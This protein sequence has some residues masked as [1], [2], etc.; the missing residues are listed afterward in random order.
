MGR[1]LLA[2]RGDDGHRREYIALFRGLAAAGGHDVEARDLKPSDVLF[3]GAIFSPMLEEH[4]GRFFAIA[5]LRSMWGRKSSAL[6]FRPAEAVHSNALKHRVKRAGLAALRRL[7]G[8]EILTIL[9]FDLD[10]EFA[11]VAKDWIHDPQLWDLAPDSDETPVALIDEVRAKAAG[12]RV[13]VALGAQNAGKGF[14]YFAELWSARPELRERF[15][16]VAAGKVAA[17]SRASADTFTAAGGLL[18]D[19]FATDQELRS[20]YGEANLIWSCYGPIYDQASG[21]FGRAVQTGAPA[22][23]RAGAYVER[24]AELLGHPVTALPWGDVPAAAE[25]LLGASDQTVDPRARVEAMRTR[26]L[27]VLKR[28]LGLELV[29]TA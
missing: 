12:R 22:I 18:F 2:V 23:V 29:W 14:D 25:A 11:V 17:G 26:S 13:V 28:A 20:L 27:A 16:F 4:T 7:P 5:L 6:M 8:V 9:P 10:P 3:S 19:R 15:L 24:L 21:I 1:L